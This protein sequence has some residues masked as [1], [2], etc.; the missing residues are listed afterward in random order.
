VVEEERFEK[1]PDGQAPSF[2]PNTQMSQQLVKG[3]TSK[4][5]FASFLGEM[6][7]WQM[8]REKNLNELKFQKEKQNREIFTHRPVLNETSK[9]LVYKKKKLDVFSRLGTSPSVEFLIKREQRV[10]HL[11]QEL[12]I[13]DPELE[14]ASN[15]NKSACS[16]SRASLV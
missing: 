9:K 11:R 5:S 13:K 14:S 12:G 16:S 15:V 1:D 2:R 10:E 4:E 3:R 8:R 7:T 6:N